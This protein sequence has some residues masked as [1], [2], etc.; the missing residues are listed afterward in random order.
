MIFGD[1]KRLA[2]EAELEPDLSARF[3]GNEPLGRIRAW[4]DSLPFGNWE[5]PS[6]PFGGLEEELQKKG[7]MRYVAWQPSLEPKT[8]IERFQILDD[9][10]YDPD[11][12]DRIS[13]T[14]DLSSIFTNTVECFDGT[15]AFALTPSEGLVQILISNQIDKFTDIVVDKSLIQLIAT[16]LNEWI[17]ANRRDA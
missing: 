4:V 6:C 2:I 17:H 15:K 5:D 9:L 10:L 13:S 1:P 12:A 8:P 14:L 7:D 3:M 16:G 11:L